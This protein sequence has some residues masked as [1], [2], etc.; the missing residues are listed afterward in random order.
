V[1]KDIEMIN[2][3]SQQMSLWTKTD[4][5][6]ICDCYKKRAVQ[7]THRNSQRGETIIS[8]ADC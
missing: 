4:S 1:E 6:I 5:L 8:N 3:M 2:W 7:W